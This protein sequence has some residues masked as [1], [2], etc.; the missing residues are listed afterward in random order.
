M[1]L[2]VAFGFLFLVPKIG[3]SKMIVGGVPDLQ[4]IREINKK[5][6]NVEE[7]RKY[8]SFAEYF[9]TPFFSDSISKSVDNTSVR[10]DL[11]DS[12]YNFK[13]PN[14]VDSSYEIRNSGPFYM[15]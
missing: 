5:I 7:E 4:E 9:C 8:Q 13:G 1:T 15:D 10:I 6:R 11:V 14:V 3:D 12:C 2:V